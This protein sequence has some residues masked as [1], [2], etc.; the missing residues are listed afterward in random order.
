MCF[1][2]CLEALFGRASRRDFV[3]KGLLAATA[4]ACGT[5]AVSA[6]DAAKP[7]PQKPR[8]FTTVLDLTHIFMKAF[9]PS[10]D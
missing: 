1:P 6:G 8:S 10:T 9:R 4:V 2:L 7:A 3:K 5:R